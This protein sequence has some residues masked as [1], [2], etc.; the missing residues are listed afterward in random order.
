[1]AQPPN[2]NGMAPHQPPAQP[3]HRI[4]AADVP[5]AQRD[6]YQAAYPNGLPGFYTMSQTSTGPDGIPK[7]YVEDNLPA[8][9]YLNAPRDSRALFSRG[10]GHGPFR[11]I[12]HALPRR[13]I[14]LWNCNEIQSVCNSLRRI[15]W[16]GF[17]HM[18]VPQSWDD[19]WEY[20]DA[21]DV[22]H[23][24]ATNVWNIICH[25]FDENRFLLKDPRAQ[26]DFEIGCWLDNW[27]LQHHHRDKLM[28][29]EKK[30]GPI[31]GVL[32]GTD[33]DA[34]GELSAKDLRVMESAL[35]FRHD[36]LT[37]KAPVPG[38]RANDLWTAI[39]TGNLHNWL[40]T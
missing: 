3:G 5:L 26:A 15:Y 27:L 34:L 21:H 4:Y 31:I 6:A 1:M 39:T 17:M 12:N 40:G 33:I 16:Y 29:Y 36:M 9:F 23:Y 19:L 20:F 24:G 11:P 37:A 18:E 7:E 13:I 25:L 14:H 30:D 22:F 28:A 38:P 35:R 2:Q 10:E 32:E 8:M